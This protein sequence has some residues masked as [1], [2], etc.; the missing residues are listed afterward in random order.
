MLDPDK[1]L[2]PSS[3]VELI[4]RLLS[5]SNRCAVGDSA[6]LTELLGI[7]RE[8][9]EITPL[10][11]AAAQYDGRAEEAIRSYFERISKQCFVWF[12]YADQLQEHDDRVLALGGIRTVDRKTRE[13]HETALA[14][15]YTVQDGKVAAVEAFSSFA[16]ARVAL[17][18]H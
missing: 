2:S 8:D 16:D 11:E 13:D 18:A 1:A 12:I 9:A 7:Y 17:R 4:D 5:L 3:N 10:R 14:L 6:A 15:M